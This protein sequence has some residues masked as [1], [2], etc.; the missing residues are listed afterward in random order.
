MQ[1]EELLAVAANTAEIELP[2]DSGKRSPA[3]DD[4]PEDWEE[5]W[6]RLPVPAEA[7]EVSNPSIEITLP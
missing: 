3:I 2:S 5:S 7:G 6:F 1:V 4:E